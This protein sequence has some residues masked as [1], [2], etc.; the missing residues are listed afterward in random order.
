MTLRI[1][2]W[3]RWPLGIRFRGRGV[4]HGVCRVCTDRLL[5]P[6]V[7][8][9]ERALNLLVVGFFAAVI[10]CWVSCLVEAGHAALEV[11][12]GGPAIAAEVGR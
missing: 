2:A 3:C 12:R 9:W 11:S 5:G 7:P 1:C 8:A 6:A 10:F 4:T